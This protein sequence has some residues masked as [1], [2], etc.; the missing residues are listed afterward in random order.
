MPSEDSATEKISAKSYTEKSLFIPLNG[1]DRLHLKR[2]CGG[3]K[4]PV[5]FLLHGSIENGKIFY[6]SSGKGFAPYLASLGFDV[7]IADLR[8]RGQST[9]PIGR[10]SDYGLTESI[11]EELP[12]FIN[13][14]KRIRGDVPQH[15]IAHSWGGI[16]LLCYYARNPKAAKISSMV[17]F[18]TK[19][20]ITVKGWKKFWILNVSYNLL[21]RLVIAL[22]GFVETKWFRAGSDNETAKARQQTYDWVTKEEWKGE[23]GF[24]Y[25]KTLQNM[26]LP[27]ILFLAGTNDEVLGHHSDVKLLMEEIQQSNSEFY[28]AGKSSGNLHD[29]DH[30]SLLTYHDAPKDHFPYVVQ[31]MQKQNR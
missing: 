11:N 26:K 19:R 20:R 30:I 21:F 22:R 10:N 13:E 9:P 31:W 12:A 2:F 27:P 5:A 3:E 17:F 28:L 7:F 25:A 6:S 23:D 16:L 18:A 14:I 8:G 29:Y 4:G 24:D 15:W 1:T